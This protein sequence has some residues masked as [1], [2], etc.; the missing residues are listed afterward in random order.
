M[1][2][3]TPMVRS[4][5]KFCY[6]ETPGR[7]EVE[8]NRKRRTHDRSFEHCRGCFCATEPAFTKRNHGLCGV[9]LMKRH[10][11]V[12]RGHGTAVQR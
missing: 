10:L 2:N 9:C 6:G 12:V 5:D 3:R 1:N 11:P 7:D 4:L 8:H